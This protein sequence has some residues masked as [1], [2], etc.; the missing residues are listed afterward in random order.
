MTATFI[1]RSA[2]RRLVV[3]GHDNA[4]NVPGVSGSQIWHEDNMLGTLVP[5]AASIGYIDTTDNLTMFA[6]FQKCFV[7]NGENLYVVDFVNTR[8]SFPSTLTNPPQFGDIISQPT[9]ADPAQMV[10]DYIDATDKFVYGYTT[11]GTWETGKLVSDLTVPARDS[12]IPAVASSDARPFWYAWKPFNSMAVYGALPTKAYLGCLY[13]GRCVLSGNPEIPYQWYM[14]RQANPWD[15]TYLALDSQS[16][17]TGGDGTAGKCGD[18]ITALAPYQDD[19]LIMG[20]STSIWVLRGDPAAGGSF[21]LMTDA[22]GIFGANSWCWDAGKNFYFL[23]NNGIYVIKPGTGGTP[24]NL[25]QNCIPN[26]VKELQLNASVHRVTMCYDKENQG[27]LIAKTTLSSGDSQNYWLDLR[28]GGFFPETYPPECG[29][30]SAIFYDSIG[31]SYRK[32]ILGCADGYIR[33]FDTSQVNDISTSVEE[34]IDSYVTVGPM[35][36]GA[37]EDDRGRLHSLTIVEGGDTSSETQQSSSLQ[38]DVYVDNSAESVISQINTSVTPLY[39]GTTITGQGR[40][41]RIRTKARG[42][43]LAV[44]LSNDVVDETFAL[45][46]VVGQVNPAGKTD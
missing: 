23:G 37:S 3:A 24:E 25:T 42:T 9:G 34:P 21:D 43:Y 7:V 18:I 17:V 35:K 30:Y 32:M 29:V 39:S 2:K 1:D 12:F 27:I 19:Y 33:F 28:T 41:P 31:S 10:V 38:Y 13:R 4:A 26:F 44:K 8:L 11:A 36:M 14:S 45:E 16:P 46:K 6:G 40:K 20:A 15:W 22:T 5:L